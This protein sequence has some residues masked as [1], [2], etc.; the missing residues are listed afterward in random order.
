MKFKFAVIKNLPW[1]PT[2]PPRRTIDAGHDYALFCKAC[3]FESAPIGSRMEMEK[4]VAGHN[5]SV[6]GAKEEADA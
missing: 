2:Y 4:R 6:H 3:K 1:P 5:R